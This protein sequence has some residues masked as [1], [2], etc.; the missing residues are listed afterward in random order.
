MDELIPYLIREGAAWIRSQRDALRPGAVPLESPLM[1]DLG[2]YFTSELLAEVRLSV[3]SAIPNPSFY[4]ELTRRG[5]QIPLDMAQM[6]GITYD[7]TVLITETYASL[8][9]R[10]SLLF[11]ECVHV[12][13]YRRLGV[14]RFMEEYVTGWATNGFDYYAIPLE[15][16]AYGLQARFEAGE[17]F[18][19]EA[20]LQD[21]N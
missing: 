21:D 12:A 10:V 19:V 14:D 3:D 16:E 11:H 15:R 20:E 2:V 17:V 13:Q 9:A 4:S 5:F 7:D 18:S 6:A 8:D 1:E